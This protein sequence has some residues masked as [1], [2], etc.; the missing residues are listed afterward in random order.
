MENAIFYTFSTIPQV[1]AGAIALIGVF[2]L[3]KIQ[4][5]NTSL[6]GLSQNFIDE[7]KIRSIDGAEFDEFKRNHISR[8]YEKVHSSIKEVESYVLGWKDNPLKNDMAFI[9]GALE[10]SYK[11]SLT[12]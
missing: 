7:G 8:E 3:Y 5:L 9:L 12:K 6:T 1:L 2:A 11:Y 4:E 10:I